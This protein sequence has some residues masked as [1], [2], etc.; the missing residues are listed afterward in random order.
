[1]SS[2]IYNKRERLSMVYPSRS[3]AVKVRNMQDNQVIALYLK[4]KREG[5][6]K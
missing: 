3:W 1:V 4:F 6:I 2:D 5:K